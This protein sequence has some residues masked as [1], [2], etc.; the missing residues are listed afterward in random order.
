MLKTETFDDKSS[1]YLHWHQNKQ[2]M[3]YNLQIF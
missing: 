1:K 2:F 3:K